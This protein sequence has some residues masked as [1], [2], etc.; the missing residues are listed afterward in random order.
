MSI[1]LGR[2]LIK[3]AILNDFALVDD[4]NAVALLNRGH[5]MCNDDGSTALHGAVKSLL[6]DL[7]TLLVQG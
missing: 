6:H 3:S 2:E 5:P 7:L 1:W 4:N